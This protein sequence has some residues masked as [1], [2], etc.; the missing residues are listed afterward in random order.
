MMTRT[1]EPLELDLCVLFP[2]EPFICGVYGRIVIDTLQD[3]EAE[4]VAWLEDQTLPADTEEVRV[5]AHHVPAEYHEDRVS[6]HSYW[7]LTILSMTAHLPDEVE[8]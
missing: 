1:E 7:D 8:A 4:L 3:I 5:M 6:V 2:A